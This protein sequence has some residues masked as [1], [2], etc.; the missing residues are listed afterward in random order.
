MS[1]LMPYNHSDLPSHLKE[2]FNRFM[3]AFF[4]DG[5]YSPS[6]FQVDLR[7]TNNEYIIDAD[8]PGL[9]KEDIGLNYKNGYLTIFTSRN[10]TRESTGENNYIRR[11]RRIG[12]F[13]RSFHIDNVQEDKIEAKFND[14]VLTVTLPK[15][16][17]QATQRNI[18]I[19]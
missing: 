19:H 2:Y 8:L 9:K 3:P 13:Q 18:P 7:E 10:E 12:Q 4:T 14:G 6:E 5:F 16:K 1:G 17:N 11:E 15:D